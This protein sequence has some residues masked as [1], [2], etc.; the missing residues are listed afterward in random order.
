VCLIFFFLIIIKYF[1]D[2][3]NNL[4]NH[5]FSL[6]LFKNPYLFG[7]LVYIH[8]YERPRLSLSRR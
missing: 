3:A 5:V 1:I 4:I 8:K 7:Y 2:D 6:Y